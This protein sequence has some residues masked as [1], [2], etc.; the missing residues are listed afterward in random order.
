M[1]VKST[2]GVNFTKVLRAAFMH[3][4]PKSAKKT[5]KFSSFLGSACV[6]AGRKHIDEI[7]PRSGYF[8]VMSK[9]SMIR[10]KRRFSLTEIELF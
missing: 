6:K 9:I 3:A 1:L 7:D 4:D 5:V 8:S 2:P 10:L